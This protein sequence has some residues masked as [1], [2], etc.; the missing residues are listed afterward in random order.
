MTPRAENYKRTKAATRTEVKAPN[1]YQILLL[2]SCKFKR[3]LRQ[4]RKFDYP[5]IN[6]NLR[7]E[8][9]QILP[10]PASPSNSSCYANS[11]G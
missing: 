8:G 4:A 1:F 5:G 6:L 11:F 3:S 10:N 7:G 2:G 9:L